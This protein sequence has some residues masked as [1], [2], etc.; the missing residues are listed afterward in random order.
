M[1]NHKKMNVVVVGGGGAGIMAAL[2]AAESG[3]EQHRQQARHATQEQADPRHGALSGSSSIHREGCAARRL[4]PLPQEEVA[5]Q[6]AW[7]G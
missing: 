5:G 6:T 2:I 1:N 4:Q 3:A 7:N